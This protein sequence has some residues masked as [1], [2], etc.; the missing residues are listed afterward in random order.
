MDTYE[1]HYLLY[2]GIQYFTALLNSFLDASYSTLAYQHS[3]LV[4]PNA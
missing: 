4:F 1:I 3:F 2:T